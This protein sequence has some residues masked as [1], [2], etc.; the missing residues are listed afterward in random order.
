MLTRARA[1]AARWA[2]PG[3]SGMAPSR[4]RRAGAG[5]PGRPPGPRTQ[6]RPRAGWPSHELLGPVARPVTRGQV[7]MVDLHLPQPPVQHATG[8]DRG[9]V[10]PWTW[11]A[12]AASGRLAASAANAMAVACTSAARSAAERL[13]AR[14]DI[15]PP[16]LPARVHRGRDA[17]ARP[18]QQVAQ[19]VPIAGDVG[20]HMPAG[21]AGQQGRLTHGG[22]RSA[23]RRRRAAG[24]SPPRC[25]AIDRADLVVHAVLP[26]P[27]C[28][29]GLLAV[30]GTIPAHGVAG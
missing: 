19:A 20:Q 26:L 6:R 24:P 2:A 3:R 12:Q 14:L 28:R 7:D 27:P 9:P 21:P 16:R 4:S 25:L 30:S 11:A 13:G 18:A 5:R 22:R 23:R 1:P 17:G 15:G 8:G 10:S 29:A